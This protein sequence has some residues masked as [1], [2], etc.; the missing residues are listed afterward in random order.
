M[1]TDQLVTNT[2]IDY[3]GLS[4]IKKTLKGGAILAAEAAEV[5]GSKVVGT[6]E[7]KAAKGVSKSAT[8]EVAN[9]AK[10]SN[11]KSAA[12]EEFKKITKGKTKIP[13]MQQS[14][15]GKKGEQLSEWATEPGPGKPIGQNSGFDF[16]K[17][18]LQQLVKIFSLVFYIISLPLMP[19][20]WMFKKTR[21]S[22]DTTYKKSLRPL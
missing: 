5:V 7:K 1:E 19:W 14:Y 4:D 3:F 16:T 21:Q 2:I 17:R 22:L 12:H 11:K 18:M 15:I 8:K 20:I 13:G 10:K 6:V 9:F